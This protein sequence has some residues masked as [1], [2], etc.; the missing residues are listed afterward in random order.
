MITVHKNAFFT[1]TFF[2]KGENLFYWFM[3]DGSMCDAH[4]VVDSFIDESCD[5]DFE[6]GVFSAKTGHF[7]Q[8]VWKSSK[9]LGVGAAQAP[10]SGAWYIV[11][12]YFPPGNV[13]GEFANNV[14][15]A[16]T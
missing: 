15:M 11:C 12:N 2:L 13:R 10:E 1:V 4:L 16:D 9:K 8:V 6:K 5:Y 3:S 7:T 14:F